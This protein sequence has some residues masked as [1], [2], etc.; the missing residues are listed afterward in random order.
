MKVIDFIKNNK[1]LAE[2]TIKTEISH[3][4]SKYKHGNDIL[5]HRKQ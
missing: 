5:G 1:F 3:L 4:L 2:L